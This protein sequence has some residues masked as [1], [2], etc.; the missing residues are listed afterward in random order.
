MNTLFPL[1][2]TVITRAALSA[3]SRRHL[4]ALIPTILAR[5]ELGDWGDLD[6]EDRRANDLALEEGSRLLSAYEI[7]DGFK[8]LVITEAD[9]SVTTILL[10]SE[11]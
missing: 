2:Q 7:Q 1:G 6:E 9:R 5:H 8:V 4:D 11:Y 3:F 10:P